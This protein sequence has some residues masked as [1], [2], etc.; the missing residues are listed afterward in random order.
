MRKL[1]KSTYKSLTFVKHDVGDGLCSHVPTR[2]RLQVLCGYNA[3]CTQYVGCS[4]HEIL[5]LGKVTMAI[6]NA[7]MALGM[8]AMV[9]VFEQTCTMASSN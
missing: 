6:G 8:A 5:E 4:E 3:G 9:M 2:T 1:Q 7:I